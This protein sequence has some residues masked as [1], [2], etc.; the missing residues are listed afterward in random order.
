MNDCVG[1]SILPHVLPIFWENSQDSDVS[2]LSV[3]YSVKGH[4]IKSTWGKGV[5]SEVW[6]KLSGALFQRNPT[7]CAH[8]FQQ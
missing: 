1:S 7:G 2:L 5:W 8:C 6:I 4:R 3:V